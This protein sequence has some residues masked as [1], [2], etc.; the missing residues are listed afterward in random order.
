MSRPSS[1][2]FDQIRPIEII[3]N[4]LKHAEGSCLFKSGATEVICSAS[5]DFNVPRWLKGK[6]KGWV[7]AEYG[8]L[9]RATGDRVNREAA[10]GKQSGRTQEIQRLIGRSLRAIVDLQK[11]TELQ[12]KIDCDVINADGG[13]RVAAINGAYVALFMAI[14]NLMKRKII[15]EM[16]IRSEV[17][18][19][20]CGIYNGQAIV[21][22]DY[23]EDSNIEA[24]VN[25]VLDSSLRVIEIQG[26]AEHEPFEF[27]FFNQMTELA[28]NAVTE[29]IKAQ[30][31]TLMNIN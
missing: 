28:K 11:L 14:S 3:P 4:Y 12:I 18:A 6:G 13:T 26:T 22:L 2:K 27:E 1:R 16:P 19:I 31:K 9:P 17:A 23:K 20:S 7:T 8:M 25:F 21:D 29:I 30:R 5:V 15:K 24:D 10:M